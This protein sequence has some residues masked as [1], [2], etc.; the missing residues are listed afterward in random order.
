MI[1]RGFE[2]VLHSPGCVFMVLQPWELWVRYM[3]Y[4]LRGTSS[5]IGVVLTVA[6][7]TLPIRWRPTGD[8]VYTSACCR[9]LRVYVYLHHVHIYLV[10]LSGRLP[11][12]KCWP[13]LF[14]TGCKTTDD[15]IDA[16]LPVCCPD[17]TCVHD[18]TD[19]GEKL[20]EPTPIAG[21]QSR[22]LAT[23]IW[24]GSTGHIG[25]RHT[26]DCESV[27][28]LGFSLSESDAE[29]NKK[30]TDS[31]LAWHSFLRGGRCGLFASCPSSR[32]WTVTTRKPIHICTTSNAFVP[33]FGNG[34]VACLFNGVH[35]SSISW[36]TS[37]G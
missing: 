1:C 2:V 6:G 22:K 24:R 13:T 25:T 16:D 37:I 28:T 26:F 4:H 20:A 35:I 29:W 8:V 5:N 3:G 9:G 15:C 14:V 32:R 27:A 19:C 36:R 34:E 21:V 7:D 31:P 17:G 10:W 33:E 23:I 11:L 30:Q 12:A 18:F